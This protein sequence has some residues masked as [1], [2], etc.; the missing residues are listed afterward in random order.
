MALHTGLLNETRIAL[1][2][3][4]DCN[5]FLLSNNRNTEYHIGEFK[6]LS[7][8]RISD[9]GLN[10]SDYRILDSSANWAFSPEFCQL[11]PPSGLPQLFLDALFNQLCPHS[12]VEA[13]T[14]TAS[15]PASLERGGGEGLICTVMERSIVYC[16]TS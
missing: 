13:W 15:C 16:L 4:L 12:T 14:S 7:D 1:I 10:L 11:T 5:F 6:K 8:Y 3:V 2:G 9:Q